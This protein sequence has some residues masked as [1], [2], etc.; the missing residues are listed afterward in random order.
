MF[1]A[2]RY[3]AHRYFAPVSLLGVL[4]S[5]PLTAYAQTASTNQSTLTASVTHEVALSEPLTASQTHAGNSAMRFLSSSG[6]LIYLTAGTLVPLLEDGATGKQHALRTLDSLLAST[7]LTEVLKR[8]VQEKRPDD[9]L[10]FNSF[11]SGHATAAFTVA[12]VESHYHPHQALF[13]YGGA[14]LISYSRV[15]LHRHYY[16]DVV[17]GAAVGYL[18]TRFELSRSH[19][20]ILVPFIKS[21]PEGGSGLSL[22]KSF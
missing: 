4:C 20:L 19:G 11:P 22:T 12:T 16:R 18:T 8:I 1:F 15:Q 10:A 21:K 13:W 3:F 2:H 9:P 14:A 5:G 7:L 17:A 6:N